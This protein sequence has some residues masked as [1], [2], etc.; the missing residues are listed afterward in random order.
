MKFGES[1]VYG[2]SSYIKI[3]T[4]LESKPRKIRKPAEEKKK[5]AVTALFLQSK[6]KES[7]LTF[8]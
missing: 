6:V 3:C 1:R 2:E 4:E 5:K 7:K 8:L